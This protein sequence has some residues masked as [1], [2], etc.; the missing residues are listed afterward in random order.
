MILFPKSKVPGGSQR[1]NL[2]VV[3]M[4]ARGSVS[5]REFENFQPID[6]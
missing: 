3:Y 2:L 6:L 1:L 4:Y 5:F